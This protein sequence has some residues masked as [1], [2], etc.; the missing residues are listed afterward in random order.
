MTHISKAIPYFYDFILLPD[1]FVFLPVL[2]MGIKDRSHGVTT[3]LITIY[4]RFNTL[5]CVQEFYLGFP[6]LPWCNVGNTNETR[7]W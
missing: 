4:I 5:I 1:R 3:S 6:I 2:T 7:V